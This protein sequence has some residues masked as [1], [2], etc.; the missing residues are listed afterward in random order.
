MSE[1]GEGW[2]QIA[3]DVFGEFNLIQYLSLGFEEDQVNPAAEGWGGDRYGV[4]YNAANDERVMILHLVW[5]SLEDQAEFV[6]LYQEWGN[7]FFGPGSP[8]NE[9]QETCWDH[10]TETLCLLVFEDGVVISRSETDK[11]SQ[12]ING[13]LRLVNN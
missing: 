10:G 9:A 5:D 1:L 4:Y 8:S 13:V 2:E 11:L 6:D 12:E 7:L 3:D